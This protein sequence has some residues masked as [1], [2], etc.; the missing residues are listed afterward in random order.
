MLPNK[1]SVA[2][3]TYYL[4][5]C[6]LSSPPK[7]LSYPAFLPAECTA[8]RH[9]TFLA[10]NLCSSRRSLTKMRLKRNRCN[11]APP[12]KKNCKIFSVV[13]VVVIVDHA[14]I[15]KSKM[16]TSLLSSHYLSPDKNHVLA[17]GSGDFQS[18]VLTPSLP[19]A[20]LLRYCTSSRTSNVS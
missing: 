14:R 16:E 19:L 20:M 17:L 7:N 9:K 5:C 10:V 13:V 1:D 15:K 2:D 6:C 11:Y 18:R 3:V 12:P 4:C 8:K